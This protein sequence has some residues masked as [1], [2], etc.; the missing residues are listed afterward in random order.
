MSEMLGQIL[1]K[2]IFFNLLLLF[3]ILIYFIIKKNFKKK[4]FLY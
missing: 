1:I 3:K 4:F 2:K